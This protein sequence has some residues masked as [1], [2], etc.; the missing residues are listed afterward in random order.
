MDTL[1]KSAS[2]LFF[3]LSWLSMGAPLYGQGGQ[4][5]Q[6]TPTPD[7]IT[8]VPNRP[9]FASTAEAVQRGVLEIE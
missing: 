6:A 7:E 5:T 1:R 4:T 8:A 2:L 9:T 3:A